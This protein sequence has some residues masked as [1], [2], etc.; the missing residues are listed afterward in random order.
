M[1]GLHG[2]W[3]TIGTCDNII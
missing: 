2:K 1:A 3:N